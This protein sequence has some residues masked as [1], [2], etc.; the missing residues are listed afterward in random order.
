MDPIALENSGFQVSRRKVL[1]LTTEPLPL[2]GYVTSGAGLRAWGLAEGLR[3]RGFEVTVAAPVSTRQSTEPQQPSGFEHAKFFHRSDIAGV[4]HREGPDALV[5]QHWG[6]GTELPEITVPL[7]VDLAG[8]HLLE[9][10]YWGTSC[11]ER[12][13]ADKIHLL[14]RADFVLCSGETQRHYFIPL[15]HMAGY[16]VRQHPFPTIPF[17]VP[18]PGWD[19]Q[20]YGN[21][22]PTDDH[23]EPFSFVYGGAFL[24]WQDPVQPIRWLLEE[25]DKAGRGKLY[26]Y[27]GAHPVADASGGKFSDLVAW[28]STHPRVELRP[29][30]PFNRL[31]AEYRRYSVALDLMARNP[32]RELA[33]TTRTMIYLYCGL[34]VIY[35][36]YSEVSG[37]IDR[38]GCGWTLDP[39]DEG[40]FRRTVRSILDGSAD[41]ALLRRKAQETAATYSWDVTIGPLAD[42]CGHPSLRADKLSSILALQAA[43]YETERLRT[44]RDAAV[45][46]LAALEGKLIFRLYRRIARMGFL[47]APLA[48]CAGLVAA[49]WL[50]WQFRGTCCEPAGSGPRDGMSA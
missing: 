42:F 1:V 39:A 46:R 15:L 45:S 37:I 8:P 41:L 34:P 21:D 6:L 43:A 44:E 22:T 20:A 26:F 28:L 4:L 38:R 23:R 35:N 3:S 13:L 27:G 16:D 50:R 7:A 9:R 48:A 11:P 31:L 5:L 30:C 32:E 29:L 49:L 25:M 14:R 40:S 19:G 33:F 18:P 47:A 24:A 17:S 10:L 36:D 12:D 2:P